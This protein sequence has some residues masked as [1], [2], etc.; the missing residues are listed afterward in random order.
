[1][2]QNLSQA[3]GAPVGV[4]FTPTLVPMSRGILATCSAKVRPGVDADAARAAYAKAYADEPFVHLL[5]EGQWPTT[6]AVLGAN[7]V[8]L[9]I[10]VDPD[11]GRLIVVAPAGNPPKGTAGGGPRR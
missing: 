2:I 3:A 10:A 7:S 5:P 11:A 1:M 8:Q 6:A 4:S 9:Q